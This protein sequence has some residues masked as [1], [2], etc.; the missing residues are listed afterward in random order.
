MRKLWAW[1]ERE[2][3][4]PSFDGLCRH[5][6]PQGETGAPHDLLSQASV[7]AGQPAFFSA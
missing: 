1:H 6:L 7:R 2:A 5:V 3:E 4:H